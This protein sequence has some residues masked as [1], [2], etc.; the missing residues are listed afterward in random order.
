[1]HN[2][3]TERSEVSR[4]RATWNGRRITSALQENRM[5]L[6]VQP[7]KALR[8]NLAISEYQKCCAHERRERSRFHRSAHRRRGTLQP[9]PGKLDRWVC[10]PPAVWSEG[11]IAAD[12]RRI[13]AINLSGS[14]LS[15]DPFLKFVPPANQLVRIEPTPLL[16]VTET[17]AIR[18]LSKR[19][20]S[21]R[22]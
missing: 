19:Y 22:A 11:K 18:N 15:D 6:M 17:A 20:I 9:D 13:V 16:R 8:G 7:A 10:K 14:S 21:S 1:V 3:E 12:P 5:Y 2:P 4:R